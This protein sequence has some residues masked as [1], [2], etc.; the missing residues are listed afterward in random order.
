MDVRESTFQAVSL[1]FRVTQLISFE[2]SPH[3]YEIAVNLLLI[4]V[5]GAFEKL[6]KATISSF[7]S[8]C[9][10]VCPHATTRLK[11]DGFL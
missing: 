11:L 7:M 10:S 8:A 1:T 5:L 3:F 4:N 9:L 6:R 2:L